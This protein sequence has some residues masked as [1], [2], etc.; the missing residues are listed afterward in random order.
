[1]IDRLKVPPAVN[2]SC[3]EVSA[4]VKTGEMAPASLLATPNAVNDA[5]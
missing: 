3:S 1:M 2:R 4:A 5:G